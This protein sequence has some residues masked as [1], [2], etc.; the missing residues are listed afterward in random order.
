MEERRPTVVIVDD[1][2]D[3]VELLRRAFLA[4]GRFE[5][6]GLGLNGQEAINLTGEKNPA[7]I[8]MDLS[9]PVMTGFEAIPHIHS[10]APDTKIVAMSSCDSY[11]DEVADLRVDAF[12]AKDRLFQDA[13]MMA[14]TVAAIPRGRS[15][16]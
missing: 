3:S 5:V 16:I 8:V 11:G 4:D 6:A 12:C 9:M 10:I 13:V 14:A 7:V 1:D 2:A 15:V